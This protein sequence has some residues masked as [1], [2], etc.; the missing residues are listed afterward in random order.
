[1]LIFEIIVQRYL[2]HFLGYSLRRLLTNH[3]SQITNPAFRLE[4]RKITSKK[5]S[6]CGKKMLKNVQNEFLLKKYVVKFVYIKNNY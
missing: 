4:K 1:M 3:Q 2:S 6:F 5:T